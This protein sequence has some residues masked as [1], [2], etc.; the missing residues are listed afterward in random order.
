MS[1]QSYYF[2]RI[3]EQMSASASKKK[4]KDLDEQG[5][6]PRAVAEQKAKEQKSKL[7]KNILI[8]A[9]AIVVCAA[10]VFG[11][12]MLA[13]RPSYDVKAPVVTVGEEKITVP[14]YNYMYSMAATN[15][16]NSYS[17]FI[18]AGTPLSEQKNIMGEGTMED[19][20]KQMTAANLKEILNVYAKA[21]QDGFKLS[22]EQQAQIDEELEHLEQDAK[23]YG[24]SSADKYLAARFGADCNTDNYEEYLT[25]VTTYS[26]YASK[27]SDEFKPSSEE[28]NTAYE[29]DKDN[30]DF[31]SFTYKTTAAE[32]TKV[33]NEPGR[34]SVN[35]DAETGTE[36]ATETPA[37]TETVYTDEAKAAAKETAESY[38]KQM[39][40]DATTTSY[41]KSTATSY[42]TEEIANWLFDAARK[43]GDVM[44]FA[45]DS[46]ENYFYTVR[47]DSRDTN[48]YQ[49]VNAN[50]ITIAK[51][52]ADNT[53]KDTAS[54]EDAEKTEEQ[55]QTAE[56]KRDALLAAIQVGMSDED[57]SKAVTA[58]EYSGSTTAYARSYSN[59]TIRDFLFDESRKDGDLLTD[60]EDDNYYYVVRYASKEEQSYRDLLVTSSLWTKFYEEISSVNEI[61]VDEELL[62][63]ANT[64]LVFNAASQSQS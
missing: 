3:D 9:L 52:K 28:L 23:S 24:F 41:N 4:R 62:K 35:P 51:D 43:E 1:G 38:T 58:L 30:F 50:I 31:V 57:F 26:A 54:T 61:T 42:L 6:S 36:A 46:E 60:Y 14:V 7:T 45:R 55:T 63:N 21:K 44:V 49:R 8:V 10:A 2:E 17:F 47:F 16:Y 32:S 64:D 59:E 37:S 27:L 56:Q 34:T 39:P 22:D 20:M 5:L 53:S 40:E 25:L 33:E 12:V 29:A 19:Y 48:D 13:S 18:Q 11:V 15:F